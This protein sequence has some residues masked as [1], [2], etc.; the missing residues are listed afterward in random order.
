MAPMPMTD[1]IQQILYAEER[2]EEI[3]PYLKKIYQPIGILKDI[4][5]LDT[6]E[7]YTIV[8]QH[9]ENTERFIPH[10]DLIVFVF[11]SKNPYRQSAWEFFDYINN[12]WRRN[13]IFV[14]QQKDLIEPDDLIINIQGVHDHAIKKGISDPKVYGVSAKQELNNDKEGSGFTPL[15]KYITA[16][17]TGGKAPYLKMLNK[18]ETSK[19]INEKIDAS[20][21]LRKQQWEKDTIF[22]TDIN[23]TLDIQEGKTK[24][25]I[26]TL[27]ENLL[28]SYDRI[29][30]KT[31]NELE[32]GLSFT[33]V[34]KRSF[35]SVFGTNQNL[36]DWRADQT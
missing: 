13:I 19:S 32:E 1:T 24:K 34:L 14:L 31:A 22:R 35:S 33:S 11:E 16:N 12:E 5:I 9:Q 21:T 25:Q 20:L 6:P 18:I 15:K 23:E 36:K 29:T 3:N 7:T 30:N 4:C 28:T 17:I 26:S 10:A 8:D 2:I 27:L